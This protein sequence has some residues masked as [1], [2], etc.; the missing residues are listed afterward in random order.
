MSRI[1]KVFGLWIKFGEEKRI[2][3]AAI[4][5]IL[6]SAFIYQDC[7]E[8]ANFPANSLSSLAQK[9]DFPY[10]AKVDQIAYMSCNQLAQGLYDDSAYFHFRVGAYRS[11]S[12]ISVNQSF[13]DNSKVSSRSMDDQVKV[14]GEAP[15][16]IGAR[17]QISIR[18]Y[19]DFQAIITQ[20][21]GGQVQEGADVA[22]FFTPLDGPDF[23]HLAL[24]MVA[25]EAVRY[26]RN[27]SVSGNRLEG[28]LHFNSTYNTSVDI[29]N[30]LQNGSAFLALTYLGPGGKNS[31]RG[32]ID[33]GLDT[34]KSDISV[35]GSGFQLSFRSPQFAGG[36]YPPNVLSAVS[37][38]DLKSRG[39]PAS[40]SPWTCDPAMQFKILRTNLFA[41]TKLAGCNMQSDDPLDGKLAVV[42]KS[43]RVEDWYVDMANR[44]LIPKKLGG[45]CY[46]ATVGIPATTP[47]QTDG[48]YMS[49]YIDYNIGV[50]CSQPGLNKNICVEFA[51]I[52]TR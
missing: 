16:V 33:F 26:V 44:C 18:D 25:G 41:D 40:N 50:N 13:K 52:C 31:A 42:R 46:A 23:A 1:K 38:I 27:E 8:P 5:S 51:S 4:L 7:S 2:L 43:F 29:R 21:Q 11:G 37:E 36:Q 17:P 47:K 32:P 49:D 3:L 48:T 35:Y 30:H 24:N 45:G 22:S 14:I 20:N 15:S 34:K 6:I 28:T 19:S 39:V 9:M 12:G 10:S